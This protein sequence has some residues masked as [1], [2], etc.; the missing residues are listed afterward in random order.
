MSGHAALLVNL[1][2]EEIVPQFISRGFDRFPN[3]AGDNSMVIGA[4]CIPLQRRSGV[5]WPTVEIS[6]HRRERPL[7]NL[8]FACLPEVCQRR[9]DGPPKQI[10]RIE[11]NVVEGPAAFLLCKGTRKNYGCSFGYNWFA[12]R[13]RSKI[14][15]EVRTLRSRTAWLLDR[16][17]SG[18]PLDWLQS[19]PGHVHE[20]VVCLR[21]PCWDGER[22]IP[23]RER[24][25]PHV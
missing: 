20:Y 14:N 6:F 8:M 12:L 13:P 4:N 25:N 1:V 21:M 9:I 24:W 5:E 18:I 2:L 19:G 23:N 17:D 10:L 3:Y 16:F 7:S 11:A 22:W 15:D